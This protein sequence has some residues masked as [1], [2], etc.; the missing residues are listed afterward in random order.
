MQRRSAST[1]SCELFI[2]SSHE[3]ESG[4]SWRAQRNPGSS[5][6]CEFEFLAACA[7]SAKNAAQAKIAMP[8]CIER[9]GHWCSPQRG[10]S[11]VFISLGESCPTKVQIGCR[12]V[13][14]MFR[15][16]KAA[17]HSLR[18]IYQNGFL[19]ANAFLETPL[20]GDLGQAPFTCT[21]CSPCQRC[22]DVWAWRG[23]WRAK[24]A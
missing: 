3:G 13:F 10:S 8:S 12:L 24:H 15:H 17:F 22:A 7:R 16:S 14:A 2:K 18:S 1:P 11:S 5:P 20:A 19:A 6:L 9:N 4:R 23:D 21:L